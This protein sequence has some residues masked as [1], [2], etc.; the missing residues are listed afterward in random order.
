MRLNL[1]RVRRNVKN[2]DTEDLLDR[3][4][5]YRAGM[6]PEAIRIIEEEL[7]ARQVTPE[8]IAEHAGRRSRDTRLLPDGT[9]ATCSFCHAPAV[10]EGWDWHKLWGMVPVFPRTYRYCERHRPDRR[11]EQAAP[12]RQEE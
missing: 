3:I 7:Q 1:E 2:A 10:A 8:Q 6:E 4:T 9:A 11:S 12:E 5:V